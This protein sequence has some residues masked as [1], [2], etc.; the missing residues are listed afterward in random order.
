MKRFFLSAVLFSLLTSCMYEFMAARY[1]KPDEARRYKPKGALVFGTIDKENA[2]FISLVFFMLKKSQD[3]T[4]SINQDFILFVFDV[5][6]NT[7]GFNRLGMRYYAFGN[8]FWYNKELDFSVDPDKLNYLGRF[9]FYEKD[10]LKP[11]RVL[12]TNLIEDDTKNLA[13]FY[14]DL[15]NMEIRPVEIKEGLYHLY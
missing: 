10:L 9:I 8:D 15:T 13:D 1:V 12:W 5:G 3:I 2:T 11:H 6:E 14:P 4:L 7:T